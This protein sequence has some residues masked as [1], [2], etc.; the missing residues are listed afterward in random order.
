MSS[1]GRRLEKARAGLYAKSCVTIAKESVFAD[2]LKSDESETD[3]LSDGTNLSCSCRLPEILDT[4]VCAAHAV[5]S[6]HRSPANLRREYIS[7]SCDCFLQS[8]FVHVCIG[9]CKNRWVHP[10]SN[11]PTSQGVPNTRPLGSPKQRAIPCSKESQPPVSNFPFFLH[12]RRKDARWHSPVTTGR[13]SNCSVS[14]A[15]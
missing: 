15:M 14:G 10:V 2:R 12:P 9:P 8:L 6:T 1:E 4:G 5:A 3:R 13:E 11:L 7:S